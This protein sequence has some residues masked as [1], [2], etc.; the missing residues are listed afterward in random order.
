MSNAPLSVPP[1][2]PNNAQTDPLPY[3]YTAGLAATIEGDWQR[4]WDE[5]GTYVTPNPGEAGF[6]ESKPKKYVLDM[7]PYPS[8]VGLH[9]GHPLG[10][11]ATD[12]YARYLRMTGHNVLHTMGFDSFGLPAEQYAVQ[13]NQ[14]PRITTQHNIANMKVQLRR[15]G[16]GHDPA[17][18]VSTTDT[19]YYKWTQWI[20]LKIYN[21]WYDVQ[22]GR[23]RPM[24]ELRDLLTSGAIATRS[25]KPYEELSETAR[26]EELDGWRMAYLAGVNVNWCPMLGT[27]LANEEVTADGKS[28]RGSFP[29]YKRPLKQWMMRITAYADR[30]TADL[31]HLDWPEAIKLLQRNWIG[32]S[33][34]AR[35][36]F[37]VGQDSVTVFTTRPDTLFGATYLVLSPDHPLVDA[38]VTDSVGS[39]PFRLALFPG[40]EAGSS[41]R[42]TLGAYRKY[43]AGKSEKERGEGKVK[44]G[45]FL[46]AYAVNPVNEARIPIF[47]ADYVLSGY[48]T[49]AIMAVPAH[50]ERDYEFASELGLPIKDVVYPR[51][52]MT[53]RFFAAKAY[54]DRERSGAWRDELADLLGL[55]AASG[56]SA[57]DLDSLLTIVRCRRGTALEALAAAGTDL[58][59]N[60]RRGSMREVWTETLEGMHIDSFEYLELTLLRDHNYYERQGEAFTQPG[61]AVNSYNNTGLSL[62][63]MT[64]AAAKERTIE[65]LESAGLGLRATTYKLR[66]WLFSRQRYWGEPFPIVHDAD[67][68]PRDV[69]ESMLPVLL[70]E[71]TN[72]APERSEDP[73]APVRTPLSRAAE[74]TQVEMDIGEGLRKYTRETNTMPNWAGSC[75][76]YLRYLDPKNDGAFVGKQAERYWMA[77]GKGADA[78]RPGGVD[79]YV[80]G[81]EHAVLHLLYARFWHKVLFDLGYVTTS[82]PFQRLFNQGYIQ[83]YAFKDERGAYVEASQVTLSDGTLAVENQDKQG[84]FVHGREAVSREYGKMGK[85]LKNAV[86]PDDICAAY[87]CDT[88]RLYEMSMGPLEASKP[89][90]TRDI[91]GSFRFLQRIWRNF[92]DEKTGESRVVSGE[93]DR[94]TLRLL[95]KTILHV[96][97]DMNSLGFNT[98]ISKLIE[99]NNHLSSMA[100]TTGVARAFILM[101]APLVP[102][103]AEELWHR[104]IRTAGGATKEAKRSL[105]HE[106]FPVGDASLAADDEVE[107]PISIM[108]KPRH[109]IVVRPGL[110]GPM[111]EAAALA[112][113]KVIELIGGKQIKKVISVPGKMVNFVLE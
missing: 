35:V 65:W 59:G 46:G 17:R 9:V 21:S 12:I 33:E 16:L 57:D 45:M 73:N 94:A 98:A 109:R 34:G 77:G 110:S 86:T 66:D 97:R 37:A 10:Y 72:F 80:G 41:P 88:L 108:G 64:T 4:L 103:L 3:R 91:A 27:V 53:M 51:P 71:L 29:V 111:L 43:A 68:S 49:G 83:A 76:Y 90:N 47:V 44:T 81:V 13:H 52:L 92:I 79:L 15:L 7:F 6:D 18:S 101:L 36:T 8:G 99:F 96:Q 19:E 93:S 89:W 11:I 54:A 61:I 25:G 23:A 1:G 60:N 70:P 113:A 100:V 26:R 106:P 85:S 42:A 40:Y 2:S 63:G 75:W 112:D 50:D 87:G 32:R 58:A 82:E 38:I 84:P 78:A 22:A 104:T 24:S 69:P 5:Q 14:H 62:D 39:T 31:E 95:H 102:H 105:L 107:V 28:E 67:G 56:A 74:W 55:S 20:F 30:L 48:G